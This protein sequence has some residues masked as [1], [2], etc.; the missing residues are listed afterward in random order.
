MHTQRTDYRLNGQGANGETGDRTR[1]REFA[2]H[3]DQMR[4]LHTGVG[5]GRLPRSGPESRITD[6]L[7]TRRMKPPYPRPPTTATPKS[8]RPMPRQP[9]APRPSRPPSCSRYGP[10]GST[11]PYA[12]TALP[13]PPHRPA[14]PLHPRHARGL[15]TLIGR[16]RAPGER[17]GWQPS[18]AAVA[19]LI[20]PTRRSCRCSYALQGLVGRRMTASRRSGTP[21]GGPALRL[22]IQARGSVPS[23]ERRLIFGVARVVGRFGD[24][25]V[26]RPILRTH[27][28]RVAIVVSIEGERRRQA[29]SK[30]GACSPGSTSRNRIRS[31]NACPLVS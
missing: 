13:V 26:I 24:E 2:V 7:R 14:Q 4:Q 8:A 9:A 23:G 21:A 30:R 10:A 12:P 3:P 25:H 17:L 11:E 5:A 22:R 18:V 28:A 6:M 31:E 1:G 29:V 15:A 20:K 19:G 27:D 16:P